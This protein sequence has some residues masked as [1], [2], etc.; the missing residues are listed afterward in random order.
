MEQTNVV[1]QNHTVELIMRQTNYTADEVT[2]Q[3]KIH[4]NDINKIIRLYLTNGTTLEDKQPINKPSS[5]NQQ[6]YKE[7]RNFMD[8]NDLE[9]KKAAS[10][11]QS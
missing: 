7:I 2:E 11:H 8:D 1:I 3:L 6:I 4:N 9:K 10:T 5:V